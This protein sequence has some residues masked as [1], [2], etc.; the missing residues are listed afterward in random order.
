MKVLQR[1]GSE[2]IREVLER[3][4]DKYQYIETN[5]F[6]A[7]HHALRSFPCHYDAVACSGELSC[8]ELPVVLRVTSLLKT[9]L[10][11]TYFGIAKRY[12]QPYLNEF[13]FR[14]NRLDVKHP[15]WLSLLR[16]CVSSLPVCYSEVTA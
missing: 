10:M 5:G 9:F 15:L 16:A 14:F 13:V 2:D 3:R 4:V 7:H 8:V 12:V 6:H 1:V 11:G